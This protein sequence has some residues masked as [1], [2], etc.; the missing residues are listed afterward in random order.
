MKNWDL[1]L[2]WL[3]QEQQGLLSGKVRQGIKKEKIIPGL[4]CLQ[5]PGFQESSIDAASLSIS[6]SSVH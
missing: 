6:F 1:P 4:S 3:E 5:G 2:H